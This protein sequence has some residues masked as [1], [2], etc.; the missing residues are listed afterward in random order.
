MPKTNLMPMFRQ[1]L[2]VSSNLRKHDSLLHIVIQ[3]FVTLSFRKSLEIL[4]N[5][6]LDFALNGVIWLIHWLINSCSFLKLVDLLRFGERMYRRIKWSTIRQ[7]KRNLKK[8]GHFHV[9]QF[10]DAPSR[11]YRNLLLNHYTC[12]C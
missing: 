4:S 1:F 2:Q 10:L 6:N 3:K 8:F 5:L 7:L 9:V 12:N 11:F